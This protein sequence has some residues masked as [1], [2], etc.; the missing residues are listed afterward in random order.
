M[1]RRFC[2]SYLL[3]F[4]PCSKD[5]KI[6]AS[7][8]TGIGIRQNYDKK[9]KLN[10]SRDQSFP[11]TANF[12]LPHRKDKYFQERTTS[13]VTRCF[14]QTFKKNCFT[15]FC[16]RSMPRN[17]CLAGTKQISSY[18]SKV[19]STGKKFLWAHAKSCA[20]HGHHAVAGGGQQLSMRLAK[21]EDAWILTSLYICMYVINKVSFKN[22]TMVLNM[23]IY[24]ILK[25][26]T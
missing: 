19:V 3:V 24:K 1:W 18:L 20:C 26:P 5:N 14:N 22:H 4:Y 15:Y 25:D 2:A 7:K 12:L 16:N 6:M 21:K 9:I 13:Y 8:I 10:A 23:A 11:A 17:L